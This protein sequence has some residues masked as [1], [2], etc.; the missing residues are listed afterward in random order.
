MG[1]PGRDG[2]VAAEPSP[3][4]PQWLLVAGEETVTG[5]VLQATAADPVLVAGR[6]R[7]AEQRPLLCSLF[8]RVLV[9][10][11]GD[12]QIHLLPPLGCG[13]RPVCQ[14]AWPQDLGLAIVLGGAV[15]C[16]PFPLW[17][18]LRGPWVK[19]HRVWCRPC[20]FA[21]FQSVLGCF[22]GVS[23]AVSPPPPAPCPGLCRRRRGAPP[24][25]RGQAL[26]CLRCVV[27]MAGIK[28]PQRLRRLQT[29]LEPPKP[30]VHLQAGDVALFS[31]LLGAQLSPRSPIPSERLRVFCRR[32]CFVFH[33]V[34]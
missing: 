12:N 3:Q 27:S 25:G 18:P 17:R 5:S 30:S 11:F 22:S 7:E 34:V 15:S 1:L 26:R 19:S 16:S 10:A 13:V 24:L 28:A 20:I 32:G 23:W 6:V 4:S 8:R 2:M 31:W 33:Q 14:G 9:A 29:P 21:F